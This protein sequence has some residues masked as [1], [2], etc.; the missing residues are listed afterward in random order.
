MLVT[1]AIPERSVAVL[2]GWAVI[3]ILAKASIMAG[4]WAEMQAMLRF[5]M[6]LRVGD[7]VPYLAKVGA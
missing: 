3:V 4:S 6:T 2:V 5:V 1:A 7:K